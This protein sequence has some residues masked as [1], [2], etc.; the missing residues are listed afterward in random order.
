MIMLWTWFC[1]RADPDGTHFQDF[2]HSTRG[3]SLFRA[4]IRG[5]AEDAF[6]PAVFGVPEKRSEKEIDS[7]LLSAPLNFKT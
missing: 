1:I 6:A 4:A 2:S 3:K 7:P 5:N